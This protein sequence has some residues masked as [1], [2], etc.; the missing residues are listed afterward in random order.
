M[1]SIA[2]GDIRVHRKEVAVNS[3]VLL[4]TL[5]STPMNTLMFFLI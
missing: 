5:V 2:T 1:V 3:E 4:N